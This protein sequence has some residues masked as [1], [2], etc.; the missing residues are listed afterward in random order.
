M[1]DSTSNHRAKLTQQALAGPIANG[2]QP[3]LAAAEEAI[4]DADKADWEEY[5]KLSGGSN[6]APRGADGKFEGP[7]GGIDN[8]P[9]AARTERAVVDGQD[10][11]AGAKEQLAAAA[12]PK[13][14][15]DELA[16]FHAL[17]KRMH[18]PEAARKAMMDGPREELLAWTTEAAKMQQR[19]DALKASSESS[20]K[21][22]PAGT[23]KAE[24]GAPV[25]GEKG[26]DNDTQAALRKALE[27]DGL[28][29]GTITAILQSIKSAQQQAAPQ[30]PPEVLDT[31]RELQAS[32][33]RTALIEEGFD[34]RDGAT[35]A[36]V[37]K[38]AAGWLADGLYSGDVTEAFRDAAKIETFGR[39][40]QT[41]RKKSA[42]SAVDGPT[43][44]TAPVHTRQ[45]QDPDAEAYLRLTNGE[46]A[47]DIARSLLQGR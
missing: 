19:F 4:S 27:E 31:L 12:A 45:A 1:T 17:A 6:G 44:P 40:Q 11:G 34:V 37:R 30:V 9:T 18:L 23:P 8:S 46:D 14:S 29:E 47:R 22:Q 43:A 33:A 5:V 28:S 21:G 10:P 42:P 35:F 38:R 25:A 26:P 39:Q 41:P 13:A 7:D 2:A 32:H 20:Q 24:A 16:E 36:A 3:P 15:A